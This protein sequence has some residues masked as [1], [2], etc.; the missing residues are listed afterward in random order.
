MHKLHVRFSI[1]TTCTLVSVSFDTL[2][3]GK[4]ITNII[5]PGV[6]VSV[7]TYHISVF[8]HPEVE[9]VHAPVILEV[10]FLDVP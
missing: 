1:G 2:Q 7:V 6:F 5:G 8:V 10:V 3:S 9:L 4:H